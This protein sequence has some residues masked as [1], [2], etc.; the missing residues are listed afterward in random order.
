ME[1]QAKGHLLSEAGVMKAASIVGGA[2][3]LSRILGFVRDMIFAK[4]FGATMAAD[5]FYV[6]Y[7]IPN[8]LRELFAEGSMSS[9]FIPVFTEY[10]AQRSH[11]ETKTF[12]Q[13]VFTFLFLVLVLIVI[14]G[15]IF[16]PLL[17]SWIA[18][19]FV[20]HSDQFQLA[21]LLARIMF[22]FLLFISFAA[23][24]MGILNATNH[25]GP[26]AISPALFNMVMI[27]FILSPLFDPIVSAAIGVVVG[28]L[29]QW[30]IQLPAVYKERF[31]LSFRRPIFPLHPGL[32]KMLK[33]LVPV[34]LALSVTQVNIFVSTMAAS[35]LGEG[36]VTFLYYGMRL[37]HFPLGIFGVA[38][39]TALLPTLSA[40]AA[41]AD[42]PGLQR[43]ISFGLRMIFFIT[44]PAMVGLIL[45]RVPIVHLLFERGDFDRLATNGVA[46][47][48]LYYTIGLWA[49]AGVR[50]VVPV[51][52][53]LQDTKTP[54]IVAVFS[55]F[56]NILLMNLLSPSL[57]HGGLALATSL[58]SMFNFLILIVLIRKKIGQ[59]D[60]KQI[61]L[62]HLYVLFSSL[63]LVPL[64]VWTASLSLWDIQGEI[65]KK[66]F[67]ITMVILA[68]VVVYFAIHTVLKS[69][70]GGFLIGMITKR[71]KR[72]R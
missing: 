37:I 70:E 17:L 36:S 10:Q 67:L 15:V 7:R 2:T 57:Q 26:P 52:Y 41:R 40:H 27:F 30:I 6:A 20:E 18:P 3:F 11:A 32:L 59:I 45:L 43:G 16:T 68:S 51:F 58:S 14:V 63:C 13:S 19:G 35:R 38:L 49:F 34:T 44:V 46:S 65:L 9:G 47:A 69:E 54:V 1:S 12:V 62:S 23:F 25:F 21:T 42:F 64:L 29:L 55:M 66:S 48:V 4:I 22:P 31:S 8:L 50:V 56:L 61:I 33:L 24:T 53:A 72:G 60:I 39:A 71:I 28:G 5:A